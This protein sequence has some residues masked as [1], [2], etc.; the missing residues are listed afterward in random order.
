MLSGEGSFAFR[1]SRRSECIVLFWLCRTGYR[2]ARLTWL[3]KLATLAMLVS[4][5][6]R[7]MPRMKT[8]CNKHHGRRAYEGPMSA[9]VVVERSGQREVAHSGCHVGKERSSKSRM[10]GLASTAVASVQISNI[11][12]SPFSD[13]FISPLKNAPHRM[14]LDDKR[15]PSHTL[16]CA[17][18]T[19]LDPRLHFIV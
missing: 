7:F 11:S 8:I 12:I 10:S 6:T 3:A 15:P 16:R 4:Q 13:H 18:W 19:S 17:H 2:L 1:S 14:Q 5:T 9:S